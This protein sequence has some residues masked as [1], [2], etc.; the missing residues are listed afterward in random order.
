[1]ESKQSNEKFTCKQCGEIKNGWEISKDGFCSFACRRK[2]L[3]N[4]ELRERICG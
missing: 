2:Y 4:K 1:M 3:A